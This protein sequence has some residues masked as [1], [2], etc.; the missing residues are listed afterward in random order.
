[1]TRTF[2]NRPVI[3]VEGLHDLARIRALDNTLDV[4]ITNG[5]EIS[6]TTLD[7]LDRLNKTRGL[8]LFL[9][10]DVPGERI[11]RIINDHVGPT[12][13]AFLPKDVCISKNKKKVGIEHAPLEAIADALAQ[14][15]ITH[16]EVGSDISR[17]DLIEYGLVGHPMAK[18][19][20][21]QLCKTLGIGLANGK[22]LYRKLRLF[23]IQKADLD[24][25]LSR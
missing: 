20:R 23:G 11:R 14:Y 15:R 12:A 4:V 1:M 18:T 19:R 21:E 5:R 13:H 6:P 10:P 7:E 9:D 17:A 2:D 16:D 3:V 24:Q 22:T 8:L 25:H